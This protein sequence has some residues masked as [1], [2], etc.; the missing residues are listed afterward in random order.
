MRLRPRAVATDTGFALVGRAADR[1]RIWLAV[2]SLLFLVGGRFGR[3]AA[4][5][6]LVSIGL[7]SAFA[8]VVVKPLARRQRPPQ[9]RLMALLQ[10]R[11]TTSSFPSGHAASAAAFATG[12]AQELPWLG[13]PLGGLAALVS[14]SRLRT[15]VHHRSDVVA[16]AALGTAAA[17]ATRRWWPVAPH[18]PAQARPAL[19][20]GR[21][22]ASPDG[23]GL[24]V[25]V[26]PSAGPA[27]SSSPAAELRDRLPAADVVEL[28]DPTRLPDELSAAADR[29]R[30]IG[31]A[32]GDGSINTA[33][34]IAHER[35][36]PLLVVPAG[37]L[38]HLARDLGVTS[39]DDA[40]GAVRDGSTAAVDVGCI[41][42][43][44]FLNTASFGSYVEL[45]DT[46]E[47]LERRIGKWPAVV[48]ALVRVLRHSSP[49]DVEI[50]GRRRQV[51]MIFIGNC[52]YRPSG[53]A[54]SWRERLDDGQLDV[55]IVDGERPWSRVRLVASV[56]T[57]RLGRCRVY[58]AR[59]TDR[60][61]VRSLQGPL[62]LARDGEVFD[63]SEAF[64]VEKLDEPLA[65]FVPRAE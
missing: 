46:R 16:G 35:R 26:N 44:P 5:R 36:Q 13:L 48:V 21:T 43:R 45:V 9:P 22:A 7:A 1:S 24:T 31:V 27:M 38:N 2:A 12:A 57:G 52:R 54:P 6:G 40:A 63:G 64:T 25:V 4:L 19:T 61:E 10:R 58:E 20:A 41:D 60:L 17:F 29:S 34:G 37:T 47:R 14:A 42:G 56:L 8:N 11:P 50:D 62:R 51:W 3:R 18:E 49:C 53:F 28:D 39:V 32:G 55:R 30:A 59:T 23:A 15:G 33:A 65:V